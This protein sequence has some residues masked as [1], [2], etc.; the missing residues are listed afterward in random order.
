MG[1]TIGWD[2]RRANVGEILIFNGGGEYLRHLGG[3]T[4]RQRK[5]SGE[6]WVSGPR[7]AIQ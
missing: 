1:Q 7:G 6:T 5:N 3:P 4:P 2:L